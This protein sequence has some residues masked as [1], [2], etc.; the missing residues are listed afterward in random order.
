ARTTIE[1]SANAT[2]T[3]AATAADSSRRRSNR[4]PLQHLLARLVEAEAPVETV[5]IGGVQDPLHVGQRAVLDHFP[6]QFDAEPPP[7]MLR[8][9]VDVREV[10]ERHAV[11]E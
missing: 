9:D 7:L 3:A 2:A 10:G 11:G 1:E 5:C 4:A 8:Q 6:H